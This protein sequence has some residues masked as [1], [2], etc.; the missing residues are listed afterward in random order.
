MAAKPITVKEILE[1]TAD[2]LK[3]TLTDLG[4]DPKGMTKTVM[5]DYLLQQM[6]KRSNSLE[7]SDVQPAE[8]DMP[9][10]VSS[11]STELKLQWWL[12]QAEIA[13]LDKQRVHELKKLELERA[14]GAQQ[15]S[16]PSV[17]SSAFRLEQAIKLLPRFNEKSVEE[18]LIGFEKV[19]EINKWP[20]EQYAS[21]LQAM[22]VGKGLRVFSELSLEDCK[23]Y[24]TLKK[25]LL[26]AYSVVSEVHRNR[27]RNCHKQASEIYAD[28][29]F[30]LNIHFKRWMEGEEAY[31]NLE[32]MR[33]VSKLE[34]FKGRLPQDLRN[35]LID[36]APKTLTEAANLADEYTAVRKAQYK[37]TD[38]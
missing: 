21:I 33:E 13:E 23:D 30:M 34:Q 36:R 15:I 18:Y 28:L 35:W 12:K 2:E 10:F 1:M 7:T 25:A 3:T 14:V 29:A 16:Q 32:Q 8:V 22:L 24:P 17:T 11:L 4:E 6:I 9:S 5:Q 27:F 20:R 38:I 19:A 37:D 31:D 26:T